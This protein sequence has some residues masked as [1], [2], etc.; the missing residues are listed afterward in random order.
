V[1]IGLLVLAA[2]G[3]V[4]R[5]N[6]FDDGMWDPRF[7]CGYPGYARL[8]EGMSEAAIER[9]LVHSGLNPSAF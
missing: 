7:V 1:A 5:I 2:W 3:I 4:Q 8:H 6:H 9:I